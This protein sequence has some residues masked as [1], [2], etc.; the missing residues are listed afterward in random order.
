MDSL[1]IKTHRKKIVFTSS[2]FPSKHSMTNAL[3]LAESIRDF[4]GKLS[5]SQIWFYKISNG[6][7]LPVNVEDR[8]QA[9]GV[10]L[11]QFM[12]DREAGKFFFVP[13]VVAATE[14]EE[15]ALGK[16]DLL[17]W[18]GSNT[19]VL[20][21][22]SAL[23]LPRGKSFG[24]RPVH[25]A[26]VGSR[27]DAPLD[28]FWSFVYNRCGVTGDHVF[29]MKTHVEDAMIRPYLNA[30]LVVTRPEEQLIRKWRDSFL[31]LYREPELERLYKIDGRYRIFIHQAVLSAIVMVSFPRGELLELPP[32]YNYPLHLY[33]DDVSEHRPH[34]IEELVILRHE[35]F[36]D[37]PDWAEKMPAKEPL[38]RWLSE[39]LLIST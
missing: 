29:S 7:E 2:I 10:E 21:E 11:I 36:Y 35:G 16:I 39:K 28:S 17:V 25:H 15:R 9:L 18:L 38:K 4:A 32:T 31:S 6:G 27:I 24:Y 26:L 3:L 33:N 20:R 13:E 37:D 12:V 8:L 14:A 5:E 22:P 19:I 23:L 30:G 1:D 34:T